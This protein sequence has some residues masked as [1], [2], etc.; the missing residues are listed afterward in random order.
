MSQP[1]TVA[2]VGQGRSGRDIHVHRLRD[3]SDFKIVAVADFDEGRRALAAEELGC[4]VYPDHRAMLKETDADLVIVSSYSFTHSLV[5]IEALEAGHNVLVEKPIAMNTDWVDRMIAAREA[6][7]K[8]LFPFH[9]YR[10]F[11]E[12][13]YLKEVIDNK[14]IGDVFEI[15]CRLLGFSRRNDWQ[16]LRRYGGGVLNNTCPHFIDLLL[17]MLGA[18]VAEVFSDL[19]LA[20]NIGDVEDHVRI[21]MRGE[22]EC[23]ADMLVSSVAA[24]PEP[25][26]TLLGTRGSLICDGSEAQIKSFDPSDLPSYEVSRGPSPNRSYDFGGKIDFQETTEPVTADIPYDV[27]GNIYSV[28]R[29][30]AKQD[31]MIEDVREVVRITEAARKKAG[32]YGG[33]SRKINPEA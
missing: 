10:Y 26:W 32:F 5:A 33:T 29:E 12:F 22:N 7:G 18:P 6:S 25:K 17:Q 24:F 3:D 8:R 19:K 16:T 31:I 14:R 2:V 27:H 20:V 9:N 1:V 11:P 21:I 28:L 23:I 13:R 4:A 15:R 30:G